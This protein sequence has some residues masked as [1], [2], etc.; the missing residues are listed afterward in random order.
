M[1][2]EGVI[3]PLAGIA[4]RSAGGQRV[5]VFEAVRTRLRIRA[6]VPIRSLDVAGGGDGF[7]GDFG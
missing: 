7:E 5:E 2:N 3:G 6:R 1:G 4:L